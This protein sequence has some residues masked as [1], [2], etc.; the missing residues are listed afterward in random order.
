MVFYHA[1]CYI[2]EKFFFIFIQAEKYDDLSGWKKGEQNHETLRLTF[3]IIINFM[4]H[5]SKEKLKALM[6][7][8]KVF[9]KALQCYIHIVVY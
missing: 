2:K 5:K 9:S 1:H 8:E 6:L 4:H 3:D 7:V